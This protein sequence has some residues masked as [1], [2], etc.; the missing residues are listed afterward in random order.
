MALLVLGRDVGFDCCM[1]CCVLG[2]QE[3]MQDNRTISSQTINAVEQLF[4]YP[5]LV[6]SFLY[7]V[8]GSQVS[9][10]HLLSE[11]WPGLS[12]LEII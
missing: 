2:M 1:W 7:R 10:C 12:G 9:H 11:I 4:L 8:T 3:L 5:E 6:T